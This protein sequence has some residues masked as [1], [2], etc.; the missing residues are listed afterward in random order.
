MPGGLTGE[1]T[2]KTDSLSGFTSMA[3]CEDYNLLPVEVIERNVSPLPEFDDPFA[4][5]R[6]HFFDRTADFRVTGESFYSLP[7]CCDCTLG[8]VPAFWSQKFVESSDIQQSG[9]GPTQAWHSGIAASS[10]ASSFASHVSASS[11]VRCKPVA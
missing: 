3:D 8:R 7:D 2:Y 10:P 6:Q 9:L 5:L 1:R 11:A 4:E